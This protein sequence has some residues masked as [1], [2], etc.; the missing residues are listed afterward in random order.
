MIVTPLTLNGGTGKIQGAALI[1]YNR[2][3]PTD[4]GSWGSGDMM[5]VVLHTMVG[6]LPGTVSWFNNPGSMASA[7]FG[8]AQS[9]EIFQ[10]GP[11]GKGWES[12]HAAAANRAWYGIENADNQN[13]ANVLTPQQL[14]S[15]AQL[16][17]FLS[18][19]AGFPLTVSNS[20]SVKGVGWHGMGGNAWGGHLDCPGTVRR[21]QIPDIIRLGQQIRGRRLWT[22]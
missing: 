12:W 21:M 14:I 8:I 3:F 22:S 9:G 17:E 13:P 5:G 2:P 18:W 20:A 15:N 11:I 6:N 1:D 4:N 7:H 16:C 19:F 10:F